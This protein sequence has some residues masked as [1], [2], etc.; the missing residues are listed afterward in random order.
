MS[1]TDKLRLIG[2]LFF[3]LF[4]LI[5]LQGLH[6]AA[7]CQTGSGVYGFRETADKIDVDGHNRFQMTALSDFKSEKRAFLYSLLFTSVP[8]GLGVLAGGDAGAVILSLG[9]SA[10]PSAGIAYAGDLE[11]AGTGMVIRASGAGLAVIGIIFSVL[12]SLGEE[13]STTVGDVFIVGGLT[14]TG[15]SVL[16]D[17]FIESPKAVRRHNE[18]VKREKID[19]NPWV[20]PRSGSAGL[21][22]RVNF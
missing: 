22:L 2:R 20:K 11:R 6:Q 17:I 12:E 3:L 13:Q 4:G 15:L 1:V 21:S 18:Q 14:I 7:V 10:G 19:L 9:I 5:M 8:S 16:Y